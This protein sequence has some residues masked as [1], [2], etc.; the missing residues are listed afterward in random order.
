MKSFG[1]FANKEE[2]YL[3]TRRFDR[4]TDGKLKFSDL[5]EAFTPKQNEYS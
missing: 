2:L 1:I 4:D 3:L 5:V